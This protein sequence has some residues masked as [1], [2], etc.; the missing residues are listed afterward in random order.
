M[1]YPD[2][3]SLVR[4]PKTTIPKT[5]AALPSSQYPTAFELVSGKN[6]LLTVLHE[7]PAVWPCDGNAEAVATLRDCRK[8]MLLYRVLRRNEEFPAMLVER[9]GTVFDKH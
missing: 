5:L 8:V 1:T 6:F 2:S 7:V 3:V 4:P 9:V